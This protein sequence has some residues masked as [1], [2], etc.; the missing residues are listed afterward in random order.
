MQPGF[1]RLFLAVL[2]VIYH[3]LR[4]LPFGM[5]DV[6]TFFILSGYWV[7]KMYD[8]FYSQKRNAVILFLYSRVLRLY[9][10]YLLCTVLMLLVQKFYIEPHYHEYLTDGIG[11][12]GYT[13]MFLLV[14]LNTLDFRLL[15]PAWSLVAEMEFYLMVPLLLWIIKKA[16]NTLLFII[17][18]AVSAY[19]ICTTGFRYNNVF[20]YI[21]YFIT[22]MLIYKSALHFS[23]KVILASLFIIASVI[24]VCYILPVLR[25]SLLNEEAHYKS[26]Y[27][28]QLLN[29]I[30][31]F[32]FIPFIT[33]NLRQKSNKDDRMFG[34][35][36]YTVYLVHWIVIAVYNRLYIFSGFSLFRVSYIAITL[37]VILLLSLMVYYL[38]EKPMEIFR[39]KMVVRLSEM[40]PA[41]PL[42]AA[43]R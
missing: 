15:G 9:P 35:F 17:A 25:N 39:R 38:F 40:T 23:R 1:F 2:V 11:L 36:S 13:Y 16:N 3:A 21:S 34:D 30:L 28:C 26:L 14:P 32:L 24:A 5:F 6:Y 37:L 18:F 8:E 12:K 7:S 22:G 27:Y 31:P 19:L 20:A 10:L 29:H 33:H 42:K 41:N 4:S 43:T